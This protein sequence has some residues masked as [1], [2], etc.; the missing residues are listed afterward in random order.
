[1]CVVTQDKSRHFG[2][3]IQKNPPRTRQR[4]L[5]L[6]A[7]LPWGGS[8]DTVTRRIREQFT[9]SKAHAA[10]QRSVNQRYGSRRTKDLSTNVIIA[11]MRVP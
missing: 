6:A 1:M 8:D 10:S 7:F 11:T 9:Q 5:I 3:Q 2:A 4:T